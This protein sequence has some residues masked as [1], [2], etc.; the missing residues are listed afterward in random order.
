[1]QG[2]RIGGIIRAAACLVVAAATAAADHMPLPLD[3]ASMQ[4]KRV[5]FITAHPDD[6][7]GFAG[8]LAATLGNMSTGPNATEVA[9]LIVTSG[10][11]GGKVAV[12]CARG[13]HVVRGCTR[14]P[15]APLRARRRA[16]AFSQLTCPS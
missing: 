10:N 12:A 14:E 3:I 15:S 16:A 8:G 5:L 9:Y 13:G 2:L 6:V 4:G 7:E 11:A 1:M